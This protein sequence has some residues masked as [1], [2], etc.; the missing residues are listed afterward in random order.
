MKEVVYHGL[1]R[2][3]LGLI[4][5][6]ARRDDD[7][8]HTQSILDEVT[9]EVLGA[10]TVGNLSEKLRTVA[11]PIIQRWA[12]DTAPKNVNTHGQQVT[13]M[14]GSIVLFCCF[15]LSITIHVFGLVWLYPRRQH[16]STL[17]KNNADIIHEGVLSKIGNS[18]L[19]QEIYPMIDETT[20]RNNRF[21]EAVLVGSLNNPHTP[22]FSEDKFLVAD[23]P[24]DKE[25]FRR[26]QRP[27]RR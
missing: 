10:P 15:L 8:I 23:R 3:V 5:E 17:Q 20:N 2:D 14:V 21:I 24:Q 13:W 22:I 19:G 12:K 6:I 16:R 9:S 18:L 25:A 11:T 4:A 26:L 7:G 1:W 27:Q